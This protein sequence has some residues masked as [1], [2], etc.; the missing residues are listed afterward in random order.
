VTIS[1]SFAGCFNILISSLSAQNPYSTIPFS[2]YGL[3]HDTLHSNKSDKHRLINILR[4][5]TYPQSSDALNPFLKR[6]LCSI[7]DS[8]FLLIRQ[9]IFDQPIA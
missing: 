8:F 1:L 7:E 2:F 5:L 9:N 4:G 6:L 3:P